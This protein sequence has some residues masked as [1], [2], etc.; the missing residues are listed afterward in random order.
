M[1]V[2]VAFYKGRKRLFNRLVSWYLK[3]PY[4]HCEL[5]TRTDLLGVSDC[6]SSSFMDGG[7]RLKRM[8]L[9]PA[10]WDLVEVECDPR[11]A[12]YWL[13]LHEE[14]GYDVL[15]LLGFTWRRK[16]GYRTKW[17]CSEAVAEMMGMP[18][19]WRFDPMTLWAS[20]TKRKTL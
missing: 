9:D 20:L 13:D 12:H 6:L 3:G 8:R 14:E 5:V 16:T 7:V 15:W 17:G 4:S 10:N 11:R 2:K 18:D 19:S 1:T